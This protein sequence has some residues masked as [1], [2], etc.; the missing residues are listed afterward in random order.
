MR[1]LSTGILLSLGIRTARVA[2]LTRLSEQIGE[3]CNV[4][5]P[6]RDGMI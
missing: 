1:K 3:T 5:L 4:A 6:E 2:I